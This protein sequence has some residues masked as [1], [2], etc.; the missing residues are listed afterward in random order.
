MIGQGFYVFIEHQQPP[1]RGVGGEEARCLATRG[2]GLVQTQPA[3]VGGYAEDRDAVFAP[4]GGVQRVA[5]RVDL[6]LGRAAVAGEAVGEGGHDLEG[7]QRAGGR[8][9]AALFGARH[10]LDEHAADQHQGGLWEFPGGKLEAN[11]TVVEALRRELIEEILTEAKPPVQE[12]VVYVYA[13]VEGWKNDRIEREEFYRAYSPIK[14]D[15]KHWRA[16]SWTTAA[17]IV[18]VVE[19]VADGKLPQT[20][21]I[22]QEDIPLADLLATTTGQYFS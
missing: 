8:E 19:L 1:A 6:D 22:K 9:I 21:F 7:L 12:D 14:I 3:V 4:V 16:I 11:E 18:A 5:R 20:G 2:L 13:V 15:G 10:F 17:S